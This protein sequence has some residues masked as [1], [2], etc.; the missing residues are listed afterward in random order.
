MAITKCVECKKEISSGA[1]VCPHCGKKNPTVT[2]LQSVIVFIISA[3]LVYW[4]Y[5][6]YISPSK[7]DQPSNR[8]IA[9]IEYPGNQSNFHNI[10]ISFPSQYKSAG[11]EIQKSNIF[12]LCNAARSKNAKSFQYKINNWVGKITSIT[13]DQG[14]E[15]AF[16][17]IESNASGF[18]ITYRTI[19]N[20]FSDIGIGSAL[21]INSKVYNQVKQFTSGALVKYSGKFIKDSERGL[22][23]TS[24]TEEGCVT[25]PEFVIIFDN[26]V[27]Y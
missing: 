23:E 19:N 18:P 6:S 8:E 22:K 21:K 15:K 14:G 13:T 17:E 1:K 26:I 16:I 7:P 27:P 4:I 2:P 12:N 24:L 3:L 11:N 20:S 5:S 10:N 9:S 25:S